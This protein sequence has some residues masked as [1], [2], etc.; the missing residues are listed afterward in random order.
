MAKSKSVIDMLNEARSAELTAILQYMGHHYELEDQAF[1]KLAKPMKEI[2][3][4]EMIHAEQLAE[5]IL[6]LEG[7]PVF[8]P[9]GQVKKGQKIGDMLTTDSGLETT[10]VQMYN[11]HAKA[12][13]DAGDHV[14]KELFEKLLAQEEEHL[15]YFR[16]VKKHVETMGDSYLATLTGGEA[17]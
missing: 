7:V 8:K 3:I 6:F 9:D 14:S 2:A 17:E 16:N 1:G 4:Q 5:R 15:D 12:C 13:A 10:A 11:H